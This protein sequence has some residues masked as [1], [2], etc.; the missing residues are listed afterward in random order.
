MKKKIFVGISVI[1]LL[2]LLIFTSP[3]QATDFAGHSFTEDHFAIEV[4]LVGSGDA[5]DPDPENPD[6]IRDLEDPTAETGDSNPDEDWQ[7]FLAYMNASRIETAFSALEKFESDLTFGDLLKP[8]VRDVIDLTD[9]YDDELATEVFH[10]NATAP[11]Q[12]LV[13]H[14][15]TPWGEDV[16][17]TNNF[18]ALIAYSADPTDTEMDINDDIYLG[19]TFSL[20]ELTEAVNDVIIADPGHDEADTIGNFNYEASFQ[21]IADNSFKF[22]INY[23]NVF[24]LWQN[25]KIQPKGV[26]IFGIEDLIREDMGGI[27]FGQDIVAASV[28]DY[29]SFDYEFETTEKPEINRTEG[30]VTTH[31]NIG[32]TNFLVVNEPDYDHDVNWNHTPFSTTPSYDFNVPEDIVGKPFPDPRDTTFPYDIITVPDTVSIPLP[33]LSFYFDD[34]AKARMRMENGFG[35]S[36]MTAT[37]TFGVSVIDP[38][39]SAL[40]QNP[41]DIKMMMDGNTYFS[42]IFKGKRVYELHGLETLWPNIP[43]D[44]DASIIPIELDDWSNWDVEGVGVGY[45]A[46]EFGLAWGFTRFMAEQLSPDLVMKVDNE[47]AYVDTSLYFTL[48]QFPAW[49][50]GEIIHDPA[51]SA[52]AAMAGTKED[53]SATSASETSGP[54]TTTS[55]GAVPGFQILSVLLALPPLYTIYRKRRC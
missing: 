30:L 47:E 37:T 16:F 32:E 4:D 43:T 25:I 27:V 45:F 35:I 6:L 42:T 11:F 12:Q 20:Q 48:T 7:F 14:Y 33:P 53:S 36:V 40:T 26:D 46:V 31:Y 38:D 55:T 15:P 51:Y 9:L 21:K 24:V 5:L 8:N 23:T 39:T 10:V 1:L 13:Q 19:Y 52:V 34:D 2:T 41:D 17:V 28:L 18:M 50:G 54:P 44:H 49:Y 29:L 3:A 22:G